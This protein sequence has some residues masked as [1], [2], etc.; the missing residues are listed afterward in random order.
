MKFARFSLAAAALLFGVTGIAFWL[1]PRSLAAAV[2][3]ELPASA[4]VIDFR[5]TYGGF[6]L[7]VGIALALAARSRDA[8]RPALVLQLLSFAGYGL[9]RAYGIAVDGDAPSLLYWLLAIESAGA[10][11]AILALRRLPAG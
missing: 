8:V 2:G 3:I 9:A 1:S 7:G 10:G 4:A 5:A 6:N 11:I